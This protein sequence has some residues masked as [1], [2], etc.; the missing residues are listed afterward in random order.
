MA[1]EQS[2]EV[3]LAD[4]RIVEW[5]GVDGPAAAARAADCPRRGGRGVAHA[6]L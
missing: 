1:A 3:K 4:G 5:H 6:A 2:Y